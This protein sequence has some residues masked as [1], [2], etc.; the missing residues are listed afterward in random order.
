MMYNIK[1]TKDFFSSEAADA[2]FE[3]ISSDYEEAA[4]VAMPAKGIWRVTWGNYENK[5]IEQQWSEMIDRREQE[6]AALSKKSYDLAA[7]DNV[8]IQLAEELKLSEIEAAFFIAGFNG[9]NPKFT[10]VGSV[11]EFGS[12][13]VNAYKNG[14][15]AWQDKE[16]QRLVRVEAVS[17][18]KESLERNKESDALKSALRDLAEGLAKMG[19]SA[20]E[21]E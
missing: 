10:P 20:I 8:A 2:F 11:N 13:A 1:H 6:E 19:G 3:A 14:K 15:K 21:V 9:N 18:R 17:V 16:S 4:I 5:P 7:R 12:E